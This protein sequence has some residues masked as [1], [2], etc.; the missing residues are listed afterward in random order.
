VLS[1]VDVLSSREK[2]IAVW[3]VVVF[4]YIWR[5]DRSVRGSALLVVRSFFDAKLSLVWASA[6][7]YSAGVVA[8]A[9]AFGFWR[10]TAIKETI[11]WF[12]GTALVLAADALTARSFDGGHAKRIARK[13]LRFTIIVEFLVNLYVMPLP[14]ELVFVPLVALL[15]AL[16]V[17][18][19][20]DP[21]L[22]PVKTLADRTVTLIGLGLM[23]WV[24][25]RALTN[26]RGL[27]TRDQAE[28]LLVAPA[29]TLALLPFLYLMWWWGRWDEQQIMRRWRN[30]KLAASLSST[31]F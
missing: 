20:R 27:L 10:T 9:C 17:Y 29:F 2:A 22:T 8:V 26:I 12:L 19:E 11:Y 23:T 5:K 25:V 3:A 18:V 6:A 16:Q 13:A 14:V 30:E 28:R 1:F 21:K 15:V 24:I 7:A 31:K 4:V